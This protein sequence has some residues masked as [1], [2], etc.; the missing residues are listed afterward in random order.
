[1]AERVPIAGRRVAFFGG[2][3]DPPHAGHLAIACAARAALALDVVLFA[4]VGAQPLKPHGSSAPFE[5]RVAMTELAIAGDSGFAISLIDAPTGSGAPNYTI[6]TLHTLRAQMRPDAE[7]FFLMGA[8]SLRG[9]RRWHRASEIPFAASLV[10][11]SRPGEAGEAL[12]RLDQL[13]G[14]LPEGL[15]LL[16]LDPIRHTT[17]TESA[18]LHTYSITNAAG[19]TSRFYVLPGLQVDISASQIRG[20]LQSA[21]VVTAQ[22]PLIPRPVAEY[23]VAHRLYESA[24]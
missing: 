19:D 21:L 23:I 10:V 20:H 1:M 18:A 4:P 7:L 2:S 13:A 9:L 11:A 15:T 6:D 5:D 12:Q 16:P 8:D 22:Q 24:S 3:F 17:A 14:L